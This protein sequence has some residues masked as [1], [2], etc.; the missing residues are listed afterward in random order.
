MVKVLK[1]FDNLKEKLIT[2]PVGI[3]SNIVHHKVHIVSE[4]I[5]LPHFVIE[6][7]Q[8]EINKF[9]V[10]PADKKNRILEA[11]AVLKF[12]SRQLILTSIR[13]TWADREL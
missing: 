9:K 10:K 11:G 4:V 1:L 12:I 8:F 7:K 6:V 2:S 3:E 5:F 13:Q